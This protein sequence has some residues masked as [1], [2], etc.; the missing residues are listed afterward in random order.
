MGSVRTKPGTS[1][2]GTAL[3]LAE[4][5]YPNETLC[6]LSVE[7]KWEIKNIYSQQYKV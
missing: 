4:N 3:G 2:A 5:F 1:L 6:F 7:W